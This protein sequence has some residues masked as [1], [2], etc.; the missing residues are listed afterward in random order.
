MKNKYIKDTDVLLKNTVINLTNKQL[1]PTEQKVFS[2]GLN[3]SISPKH[4]PKFDVFSA[5]DESV[6]KF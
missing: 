4:I 1:T 6:W 5:I 3:F 2:K